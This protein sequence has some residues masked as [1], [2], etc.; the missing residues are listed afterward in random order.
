MTQPCQKQSKALLC[1]CS[2]PNSGHLNASDGLDP[3]ADVQQHAMLRYEQ[4]LHS[5]PQLQVQSKSHQTQTCQRSAAFLPA[6]G[7]HPG[8]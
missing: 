2:Q 3:N 6:L 4:Q 7:I 5:D 1:S 8:A